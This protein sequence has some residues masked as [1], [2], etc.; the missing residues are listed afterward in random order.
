MQSFFFDQEFLLGS[1][2][3]FRG[4]LHDSLLWGI[5]IGMYCQQFYLG[6][7]QAYNRTK[8]F[9]DDLAKTNQLLEK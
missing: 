4:Q 2:V 6:P 5:N 1:H 3:P 8:V 7:Q 9:Q